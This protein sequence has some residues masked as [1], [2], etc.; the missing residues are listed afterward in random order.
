M[1]DPAQIL[2]QALGEAD[3]MIRRRLSEY[4]LEMPH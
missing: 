2:E 3:E 1:K 4:S